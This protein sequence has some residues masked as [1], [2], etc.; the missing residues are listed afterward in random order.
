MRG[1]G[2]KPFVRACLCGGGG[3]VCLIKHLLLPLFDFFVI[4]FAL[5]LSLSRSF[6]QDGSHTQAKTKT[7][8]FSFLGN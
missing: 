1:G 2:V 3:T 4:V 8:R 5:A 7:F 6:A